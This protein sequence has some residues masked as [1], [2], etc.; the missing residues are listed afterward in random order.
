LSTLAIHPALE[1]Q[2]W[3]QSVLAVGI[4]AESGEFGMD[5]GAYA[6]AC[7]SSLSAGMLPPYRSP[8]RR[9]LNR[10]GAGILHELRLSG[11]QVNFL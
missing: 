4:A 10:R 9:A 1:N 7:S 2:F 6:K 5:T 11:V 3:A 8:G